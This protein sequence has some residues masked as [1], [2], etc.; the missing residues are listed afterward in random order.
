MYTNHP[1]P[2]STELICDWSPVCT[3][4]LSPLTLGFLAAG[5]LMIIWLFATGHYRWGW[6]LA[7]GGGLCL[8]MMEDIRERVTQP[9]QY[10][11]Q[12]WKSAAW[13][14]LIGA[15]KLWLPIALFAVIVGVC[16]RRRVLKR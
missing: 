3:Y 14:L 15:H 2:V 1:P 10:T 16:F 6:T 12:I 7:V 13:S 5:G 9:Q 8:A 4:L 11:M